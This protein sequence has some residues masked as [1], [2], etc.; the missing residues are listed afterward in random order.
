MQHLVGFLA[1]AGA[2]AL[3]GAWWLW[4]EVPHAD[5][6]LLSE[7][8]RLARF[9]ERCFAEVTV[10]F[11]EEE[12]E[13]P[14]EWAM[15]SAVVALLHGE[16]SPAERWLD[17][18]HPPA[19]WDCRPADLP[20]HW[21]INQRMHFQAVAADGTL[22]E[23]SFDPDLDPSAHDDEEP[24]A[25]H[26]CAAQQ[27]TSEGFKQAV[28]N[29]RHLAARYEQV[30]SSASLEVLSVDSKP[31]R[32]A[33]VG[34]L[35][36]LLPDVEGTVSIHMVPMAP[37]LASVTA[38]DDL[39]ARWCH[40][41]TLPCTRDACM[42]PAAATEAIQRADSEICKD[43][44][45]S[46]GWL[47]LARKN[48]HFALVSLDVVRL[49]RLMARLGLT[50]REVTRETPLQRPARGSM[51]QMERWAR[52]EE[53]RWRI[54]WNG[55][56]VSVLVCGDVGDPSSPRGCEES[57]IL[58]MLDA[59]RTGAWGA[60]RG[61]DPSGGS[62]PRGTVTEPEG[63]GQGHQG[64]GDS[65]DDL[66]PTGATEEVSYQRRGDR[67]RAR[68]AEYL[69][70][71]AVE[72]ERQREVERTREREA[73]EFKRWPS[74]S[75]KEVVVPAQEKA[76]SDS[77]DEEDEVSRAHRES[78]QRRLRELGQPATFF[79]ETDAE[80]W[81]RLQRC[82][83]NRDQDV[84][85]DGSTN[86]MQILDRRQQRER[87]AAGGIRGT[88]IVDAEDAE[89]AALEGTVSRHE[90]IEQDSASEEEGGP[91]LAAV[92]GKDT[93]RDKEAEEAQKKLDE[94]SHEVTSWIRSMLPL[95]AASVHLSSQQESGGLGRAYGGPLGLSAKK[96]GY[97]LQL[98]TRDHVQ[99][100][101]A[102]V[103]IV[104][105]AMCSVSSVSQ[106]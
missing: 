69:R 29:G 102:A 72:E 71:Q 98:L 76:A 22:L 3:L 94:A 104:Y 99:G 58:R 43:S 25:Q 48:R 59:N 13:M 64:Q 32:T 63:T 40:V 28:L 4:T 82:E 46:L 93:E 33:V 14:S 67:E 12:E 96:T 73:L 17:D 62:P 18:P 100:R 101:T 52:H 56:D 77:E 85:A 30:L 88:D 75:A 42:T 61:A 83:L 97:R 54:L 44:G 91:R 78:T 31:S 66:D 55:L 81:D 35:L 92:L 90:P 38:T 45:E 11:P 51:L 84:L 68:A 70:E 20:R 6:V 103:G 19:S 39:L 23:R 74:V 79:A 49:T 37:E 80:R 105:A 89:F 86:V 65:R 8:E 41:G 26:S 7:D 2:C 36:P 21:R 53:V 57:L 47:Q 1:A 60:V 9:N 24:W 50:C 10:G 5:Y 95:L 87:E 15:H 34:T 106:E 27:L 16:V